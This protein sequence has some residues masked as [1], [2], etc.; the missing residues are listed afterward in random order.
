MLE[1][2]ILAVYIARIYKN[3][4]A[5]PIYTIDYENSIKSNVKILHYG[6][7]D[8]KLRETKFEFYSKNDPNSEGQDG[9]K[10]IISGNGQ[11]SGPHGMEFKTLL[12]EFTYENL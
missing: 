5:R 1:L 4:I 8:Q 9:Y 10:H 7:F 6:Y 2:A 12:D 11:F 3:Q